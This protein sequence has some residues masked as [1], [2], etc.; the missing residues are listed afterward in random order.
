MTIEKWMTLIH[1][2]FQC[3]NGMLFIS[4]RTAM[5]FSCDFKEF[6]YKITMCCINRNMKIYV[7]FVGKKKNG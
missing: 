1:I 5:C 2:S 4:N 7:T 3:L 6:P